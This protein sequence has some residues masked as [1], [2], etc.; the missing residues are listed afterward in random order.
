MH[1][2]LTDLRLFLLVNEAGSITAGAARAGLA[3]AS[4]SAR[5]R[6]LE[7]QAGVPLLERGR[8]GVLP[9]PA[10]LALLAH[11]RAMLGQLDALRGE[12]GEYAAGL[13]GHVRMLANTAAASEILPDLLAGFLAA[14]PSLDVE[15]DDRP[16]TAVAQAVAEGLAEL[17]IA[18]DHADLSGLE[19]H[20]F[21]DDRLVLVTPP[22]HALAGGGALGF[23]Q[24]LGAEFI[25]LAGDS[26]LHQHILGHA[27]RAGRPMRLRA[28][29]HGLGAVCRMVALGAGVAVVPERT[30]RRW[31][32]LPMLRLTDEW[33]A[34]RLRLVMRPGLPAPA[35]R[36]ADYL[37]ARSSSDQMESSDRV[38]MIVKTNS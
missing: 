37:L 3:L 4:A 35:R 10:G 22:G 28:R 1:L 13:R 27:R 33:A 36:L 7:E 11:A 21:R 24:C 20:P 5:L 38:K 8:R 29:V 12:M 9:T 23:A 34:R 19:S 18:A 15:L 26:A 32:G 16:S 2:D 14:H 25:G 30:A 31:P 6:G 17:G